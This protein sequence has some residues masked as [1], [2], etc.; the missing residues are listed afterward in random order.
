MLLKIWAF[1]IS[2]SCF[3]KWSWASCCCVLC[4]QKIVCAIYICSL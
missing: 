1:S 3:Q 4:L 2:A